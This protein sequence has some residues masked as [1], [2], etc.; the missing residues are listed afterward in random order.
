MSTPPSPLSLAELLPRIAALAEEAGRA[1]LATPRRPGDTETKGDGSPVTQADRAAHTIIERA[2]TALT[3]EVPI[4]SE[5]GEHAAYDT[6]AAWTRFWLVDPL[7][8]TKE[9]LAQTPDYTVNVALID[10]GVPVLGVVHAP[11]RRVTYAGAQGVGS[12]RTRDG[13]RARLVAR[14][15]GPGRPVRIAESRSHRSA[16][17]EAFLAPYRVGERVPAGSSLKFGFVADGTADAYVRLGPTMEWDVAAGDAVF[18][19][20][21]DGAPHP[22]PFTYNT[23][24][25]RNDGFVVGFLPPPPAVVWFTGLSGAGKSTIA[26]ALASRLGARGAAVE[27]L[28]GDALRAMFPGTGFSREDRDAHVRRVGYLA[29]RLEAHGVTVVAALISP[30]R[31]ARTFVRGLCR[32]FVEVHVATSLEDCERRDPKGL[33]A[34]A[35][36]GRLTQFT[37]IDDP[38][39]PPLSAEIVVDTA[40]ESAEAAADRIVAWLT[41]PAR[42]AGSARP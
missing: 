10:G 30:Y 15:P 38:Y 23:P 28:D 1:I 7:D 41:S 32:T 29:S 9:Y 31:E 22:S 37:G 5:E 12:H 4:L 6:R 25:L 18:R 27:T 8:G 14:P 16:A 20:A 13:V 40:T 33:Y 26:A 39:E 35:R 2:L 19:W 42:V 34:K 36:A 24:S 21:S 3:P 17:M 11:A